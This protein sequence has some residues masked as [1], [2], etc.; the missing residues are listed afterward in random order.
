MFRN[1][2]N[3]TRGTFNDA[4][5]CTVTKLYQPVHRALR[6]QWSSTDFWTCE[7]TLKAPNKNCSRRHFNFLLLSFKEN[8]AW[9][10]KWIL[11]QATSSLIFSEKRLKFFFMNAVCCS[12][13]W[14]FR[15]KINYERKTI[16]LRHSQ[17]HISSE[18]WVLISQGMQATVTCIRNDVLNWLPSY[19]L[20]RLSTIQR[21]Q[22]NVFFSWKKSLQ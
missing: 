9:C 12:H 2:N 7:L 20:R 1:T 6:E 8:E 18:L 22:C 4:A 13:D 19:H 21:H 14:H 10:F 17:T 11:C 15:V 5:H 16:H 3:I